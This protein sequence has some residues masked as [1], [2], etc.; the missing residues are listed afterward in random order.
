MER[1]PRLRDALA[2]V[3]GGDDGDVVTSALELEAERHDGMEVAEGAEGCEKDAQEWNPVQAEFQFLHVPSRSA[4]IEGAG[5][6]YR[7]HNMTNRMIRVAYGR[8]DDQAGDLYLPD[9]AGAP[10]VCLF[11]G[12]FWRMP[13]GRDELAPVAQDLCAAG[14]SVWNLEYRRVGPGGAAWPATFDDVDAVLARLPSLQHDHPQVDVARLLFVGHSAGGHLAFWAASRRQSIRPMAVIGLAPILDLIAA[15]EAALGNRAVEEFLGGSPSDVPDRY[16]G[17]SPIALLPLGLPQLVL[18]GGQDDAVPVAMSQA[19]VRAAAAA[20]DD[21]RCVELPNAGHMDF[22]DPR[23]AAH[24][25]LRRILGGAAE[26]SREESA[27][28]SA[29]RRPAGGFV[30]DV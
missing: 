21:A 23:S 12:G 19:Y 7:C 8:A 28:T 20:G 26:W 11:H 27:W 4:R 2:V 10:L 6:N 5:V 18:H 22:I 9:S 17:A 25:T 30:S 14:W 13:Y 24:A 29:A 3:L 1:E 16:Q 15:R